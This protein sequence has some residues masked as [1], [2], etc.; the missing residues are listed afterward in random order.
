MLANLAF[1]CCF[2]NRYKGPNLAGVDPNSKQVVTLFHPRQHEW[3]DHFQWDGPMLVG[4]TPTARATIAVLSINRADAL[5]VRRL[6]IQE[7]VYPL[8]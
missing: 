1:A 6:L 2:C 3:A 5:A 4:K 8:V 7:G